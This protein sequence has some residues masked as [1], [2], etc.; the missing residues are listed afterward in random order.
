M[1]F[2]A[3]DLHLFDATLSM[4]LSWMV[5]VVLGVGLLQVWRRRVEIRSAE[6]Q[7]REREMRRNKREAELEELRYRDGH[8]HNWYAP[9]KRLL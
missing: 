1:R 5:I 3:F 7:L 9:V 8:G 6:A 2:C 4:L